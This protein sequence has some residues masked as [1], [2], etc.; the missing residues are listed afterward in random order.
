M[1]IRTGDTIIRFVAGTFTNGNLLRV[2]SNIREHL[3][4]NACIVSTADEPGY[5]YYRYLTFGEMINPEKYRPNPIVDVS[6]NHLLFDLFESMRFAKVGKHCTEAYP[7]LPL[8]RYTFL[9]MLA[10]A[11]L[12]AA[13][14]STAD[15]S[16]KFGFGTGLRELRKDLK[17][18]LAWLTGGEWDLVHPSTNRP[19][20]PKSDMTYLTNVRQPVRFTVP[21]GRPNPQ[22]PIENDTVVL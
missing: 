20:P 18:D 12:K 5:A 15:I 6:R 8:Q 1:G 19:V 10:E 13:G 22:S 17:Q 21:D 2:I 14:V 11:R 4:R 3:S 9:K 7:L 16:R